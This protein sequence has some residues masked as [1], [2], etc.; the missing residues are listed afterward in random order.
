MEVDEAGRHDEPARVD[1]AFRLRA[2]QPA[3]CR[4]PVAADRDITGKPRIA[5]AVDDVAVADQQVIRRLLRADRHL[6][7]HRRPKHET[8]KPQPKH[9]DHARIKPFF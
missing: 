2:G 9:P 1:L 8:G 7:E 6:P 4:D 3:N 5:R